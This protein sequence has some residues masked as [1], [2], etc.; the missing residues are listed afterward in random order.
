MEKKYILP[1]I[2]I[3][4]INEEIVRTSPN[5]NYGSDSSDNWGEDIWE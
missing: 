2:E 4:L 3:I 5:P 1:E